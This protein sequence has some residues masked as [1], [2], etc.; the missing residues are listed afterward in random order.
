MDAPGECML[1]VQNHVWVGSFQQIHVF[2]AKDFCRLGSLSGHNNM[3]H[4]MILVNNT[5]WS[6]SSDKTIRVWDF[7]VCLICVQVPW[8]VQRKLVFT[9]TLIGVVV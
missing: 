8:T 7:E 6:C 3:V 4:C 9:V 5:V 2:S 1:E